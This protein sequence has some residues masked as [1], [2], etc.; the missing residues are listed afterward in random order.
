LYHAALQ[1]KS[2]VELSNVPT[3]KVNL[4][5]HKK[6]NKQADLLAHAIVSKRKLYSNKIIIIFS[7]NL[8]KYLKKICNYIS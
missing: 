2:A 5:I 4:P 6:E 8:I 7:S 1:A 3:I